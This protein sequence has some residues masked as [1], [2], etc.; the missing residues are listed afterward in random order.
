MH[1][2]DLAH[3]A[4][5]LGLFGAVLF[6]CD[7]PAGI[8]PVLDETGRAP[9]HAAT[10]GFTA[11]V[12]ALHPQQFELESGAREHARGAYTFR[13]APDA[14]PVPAGSY[15]IGETPDGDGYLRRVTAMTR[16]G[17]VLSVETVEAWW[18]EVLA[19]GVR[20]VRVPLRPSAVARAGDEASGVPL[21]PDGTVA[22]FDIDFCT[23]RGLED[24][25]DAVRSFQIC[26]RPNDGTCKELS[27][28]SYEMEIC[29]NITKLQVRGSATLDGELDFAFDIDP[30]GLV[31]GTRPVYFPCS[32][33]PGACAYTGVCTVGATLV[34][35]A[36][37]LRTEVCRLI[38][39]GTAPRVVPPAVSSV[40]MRGTPSTDTGFTL[41][42]EGTATFEI[43]I[44]IPK[45]AFSE[46]LELISGTD[47]LKIGEVSIGMFI[48]LKTIVRGVGVTI[49]GAHGQ[50]HDFAYAF[51]AR[52]GWS[53][54][55][56]TKRF[57][58]NVDFAFVRPDSITV[59]MGLRRKIGAEVAIIPGLP[60]KLGGAVAVGA[61]Y[62]FPFEELTWSRPP[63]FNRKFDLD[64][65]VAVFANAEFTLPFGFTQITGVGFEKEFERD[66]IRYDAQD[67][68]G[69]GDVLVDVVVSGTD[70]DPDGVSLFLTRRDA[71]RDPPFAGT[72][73]Q[74][75][76]GTGGSVRFSDLVPRPDAPCTRIY[77]PWPPLNQPSH[78]VD[79]E[80]AAL[81]HVLHVAGLAP[82]CTIE[83][84]NPRV[85]VLQ[86][87]ATRSETV[88]IQCNPLSDSLHAAIDVDAATTG[89]VPDP[90][91]YT[92]LVDGVV[93][94]VVATGGRIVLGGLPSGTHTVTLGDLSPNCAISAP[95]SVSVDVAAGDTA[96]V[97]FMV[98]CSGMSAGSALRIIV[99][100]AGDSI[101]AD[102]FLLL[103]DGVAADTLPP[104]GMA[105]LSVT[106]G[107]RTLELSDVASHCA[108]ADE[109]PRVVNVAPGATTD[110]HFDVTCARPGPVGEV[111]VTVRGGAGGVDSLSA[112]V[113]E[114]AATVAAD[115][116][117]V[118]F[119][120]IPA[121]DHA[122]ALNG[123]PFDCAVSG[124]NPL[125]ITVVN[126]G[127][128]TV[129]WTVRCAPVVLHDIAGTI[130]L[131]GLTSQGRGA[132]RAP[133]AAA[134]RAAQDCWDRASSGARG[135]ALAAGTA[136]QLFRWCFLTLGIEDQTVDLDVM[137]SLAGT[138]SFARSIS[139]DQ[140][141][142][143][144]IHGGVSFDVQWNGQTGTFAGHAAGS[145]R[146]GMLDVYIA[147]RG[148]G[149]F[150][151]LV[152]EVHIMGPLE[153]PMSY[154]GGIRRGGF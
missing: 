27:V 20:T 44:P 15:I 70:P 53:D 52:R 4:S 24:A 30:G 66:I 82:N 35:Q 60:G 88:D 116:G 34:V 100:A 12:V 87:D 59:R 76:P 112:T 117:T 132:M 69:R 7:A 40:S 153:G 145:V 72:L 56:S 80:L 46:D 136:G 39:A 78:L 94:G 97:G 57:D 149:A 111:L 38:R 107:A 54:S 51:D 8:E 5:I 65:G 121:G 103:L 139:L 28:G 148:A 18:P 146:A 95:T 61:G 29:G 6:A 22:L 106:P 126:G 135:S 45:A 43:D 49:T 118:L 1:R 137:G 108:I 91:G 47:S 150:A 26:N 83:G 21:N 144:G 127:R 96:V 67:F 131:N 17:S 101:D 124:P 141:A 50:E 129:D 48:N 138:G 62:D 119:Q 147:A 102:G 115:D 85:L 98:D 13:I 14:P 120:G 75:L 154:T 9:D 128:V 133:V 68:H 134:A 11:R 42:L 151:G 2:S 64:E 31:P 41:E 71:Q 104:N 143:G 109:N 86:P 84:A 81:D 55:F 125:A 93:E 140:D 77:P 89:T 79:C 10:P 99:S 123:L 36:R 105:I 73:S 19:G 113:G 23:G 37:P 152:L 92:I 16:N 122:A 90:D 110:V 33:Y 3:A 74:N 114:A 32:Q 130:E 63:G 25:P 142:N 58:S